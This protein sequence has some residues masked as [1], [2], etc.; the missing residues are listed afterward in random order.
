MTTK[1]YCFASGHIEFTTKAIPDGAL[2]I[3][4]SPKA[5]QIVQPI[6]RMSYPRLN[7]DGTPIRGTSV[8]LVPGIPEAKSEDEK[9]EAYMRFRLWAHENLSKLEGSQ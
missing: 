4:I 8:P 7:G 5:R 6:A 9:Y 3:L 2:P 1:A